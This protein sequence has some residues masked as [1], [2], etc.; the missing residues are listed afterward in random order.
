MPDQSTYVSIARRTWLKGLCAL[1]ALSG[2]AALSAFAQGTPHSL[3]SRFVGG[4]RAWVEGDWLH[5]GTRAVPDHGSPYFP[6][7]DSR[8]EAFQGSNPMGHRFH[9]SPT[10]IAPHDMILR[11]PLK[12]E[13]AAAVLRTPMGPI[14][15]ALNGVPFFN[16]YAGNGQS[17]SHEIVSFDQYNGHPTPHGMYHYHAEPMALTKRFGRDALL[18]VLLDGFPV[19]G[20]IENGREVRNA[21]LDECHGHSHAT[22]DFPAGIYHYHTTMQ[23]PYLNGRGF[24]GQ[25]GQ[26]I[27]A[28]FDPAEVFCATA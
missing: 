24:Y 19:Y 13:P 25:R 26:I 18:G 11:I 27:R 17:L 4:A 8:H 7:G 12:P 28:S 14:G 5:V 21:D 2:V 20:G 3:A 16:Q 1:P 9:H 15:I 10:Q 22:N 6:A 23:E